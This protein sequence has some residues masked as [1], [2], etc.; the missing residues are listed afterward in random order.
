[1]IFEDLNKNSVKDMEK[2]VSKYWEDIDILK[3][4]IE[5]CV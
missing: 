3:R 4:S 1:M 2:E 5:R